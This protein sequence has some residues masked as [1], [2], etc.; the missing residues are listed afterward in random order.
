VE[1][2]KPK[3]QHK[4]EKKK[5]SGLRD[6]SFIDFMRDSNIPA[7]E[8]VLFL[9]YGGKGDWCSHW[10]KKNKNI[11]AYNHKFWLLNKKKNKSISI[12]TLKEFIIGNALFIGT[13]N[14]SERGTR[15]WES[16]KKQQLIGQYDCTHQF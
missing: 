16:R 5:R 9:H 10:Q 2:D 6:K 12:F 3:V 4:H 13:A 7:A 15:L 14:C 1:E 8:N 11:K